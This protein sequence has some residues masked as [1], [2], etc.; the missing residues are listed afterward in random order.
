MEAHGFAS[1]PSVTFQKEAVRD[2]KFR[3]NSYFFIKLYE[4]LRFTRED[5][6]ELHGNMNKVYT[7][8]EHELQ[9]M[10]NKTADFV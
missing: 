1:G 8:R 7:E 9:T 6:H 2:Q 3:R 5:E 10:V 4:F